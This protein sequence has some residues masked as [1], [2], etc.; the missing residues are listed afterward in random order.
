[1][2]GPKRPMRPNCYSGGNQNTFIFAGHMRS[3][4]MELLPYET[5][6]GPTFENS[7][8]GLAY[9]SSKTL[10]DARGLSEYADY[11]YA[12]PDTVSGRDT[13]DSGEK[14]Y[15]W[16]STFREGVNLPYMQDRTAQP[17]VEPGHKAYPF[18]KSPYTET[19]GLKS[20]NVP[21]TPY[22]GS[23]PS[24]INF[25]LLGQGEMASW[26]NGWIGETAKS[27]DQDWAPQQLR[28][29]RALMNG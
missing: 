1:M 11:Q 25:N 14:Y 10:D 24:S 5:T 21:L 22:H 15:R 8:L 23:N 4:P 28:S 29:R 13:R 9:Q 16:A 27:N 12:F 19:G 7:V 3:G 2:E 17:L 20:I 18:A 26:A 6:F